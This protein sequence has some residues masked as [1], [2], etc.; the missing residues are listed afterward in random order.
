MTFRGQYAIHTNVKHF[1]ATLLNPAHSLTLTANVTAL[2]QP[3]KII[4]LTTATVTTSPAL[5][6]QVGPGNV[7]SKVR[8][9]VVS[10]S[11]V[12]L[13]IRT[14]KFT[15][16]APFLD[17]SSLTRFKGWPPETEVFSRPKIFSKF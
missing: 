5:I 11:T 2:L 7:P 14:V 10:H 3:L 16:S 12:T 4:A 17:T 13:P 15:P 9:T 1:F 6:R 8:R